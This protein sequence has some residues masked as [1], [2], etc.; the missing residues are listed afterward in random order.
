MIIQKSKKFL[1][2]ILVSSCLFAL[3]TFTGFAT[4][5]EVTFKL[6]HILAPDHPFSKGMVRLAEKVKEKSKGK[7]IINIYDS[8]TLGSEKDIADGIVNGIVD[9]G[10][11][12]PG[13]LGK[14]FKPIQ[15]LEAPFVFRDM[16]H[17]VKVTSG[18]IGKSLW[19]KMAKETGIRALYAP[20]YGTRYVTT[21]KVAAK[22]PAEMKGIKLRTPDMP[23]YVAVTKAMGASPTPMALSEVYLA[24]QQGVVDG[25]ENPIPTIYSQKFYEVQKYIIL[26]G[27]I[28]SVT[29]IVVSDK[30]L[31][32]LPANLRKILIDSVN[33]VGPTI[34]SEILAKEQSLIEE[35]KKSG[36]IVVQPDVN[37]FRKAAASVVAEFENIWGKGLY[38]KIQAVK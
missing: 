19:T 23:L 2:L 17:M 28:L 4:S 33:E 14:R 1:A 20:Y 26:T 31:Q 16:E 7:F 18:P 12:G 9:M 34:N 25:Q 11:I 35:F 5:G 8:G 6:A 29:P 15:V 37:A 24:L 30:K 3:A 32:S 27:H 38:D 10:F 21:A 22:T 13:E 36:M